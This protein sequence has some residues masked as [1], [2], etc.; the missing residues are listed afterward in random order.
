MNSSK[1]SRRSV[2]KG[3]AWVAPVVLAATSIPAYAASPGKCIDPSQIFMSYTPK[4]AANGDNVY[5]FF[6]D[7]DL[8]GYSLNVSSY[9][10]IHDLVPVDINGSR[11]ALPPVTI[12]EQDGLRTSSYKLSGVVSTLFMSAPGD[13]AFSATLVNDSCPEIQ[14]ASQ[15]SGGGGLRRGPAGMT[16]FLTI[17][18]QSQTTA[19]TFS[20]SVKSITA[21]VNSDF[22]RWLQ[23]A[24]IS[25]SVS[26]DELTITVTDYNKVT[27]ETLRTRDTKLVIFDIIVTYLDGS[28]KNYHY[29]QSVR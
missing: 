18:P 17:S 15:G 5:E 13:I 22:G 11:L 19:M 12:R 16:L 2:A 4:T 21:K 8:S 1:L 7:I 14:L 24:G 20:G 23:A 10:D 27:Y 6:P 3:A 29:E 28:T 9:Q 25:S 26:S